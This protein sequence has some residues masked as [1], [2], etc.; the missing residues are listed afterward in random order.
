MRLGMIDVGVLAL[1]CSAQFWLAKCLVV[2]CTN[3]VAL[4]ACNEKALEV[5][6]GLRLDDSLELLL[7]HCN[8]MSRVA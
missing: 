8:I 5:A 1:N 4:E 7:V 3:A 2:S 6:A